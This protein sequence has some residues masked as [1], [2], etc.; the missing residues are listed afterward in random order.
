MLIVLLSWFPCFFVA[1]ASVIGF[2]FLKS[3]K[4]ELRL[5]RLE[6]RVA[7]GPAENNTAKAE[8]VPVDPQPAPTAKPFQGLN[9]TTRS[10]VLKMHWL[11]QSADQIAG[12][13]GLQKGEVDLLIKVHQITMRAL[14]NPS[15]PVE[16]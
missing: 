15:S 16:A 12:K 6:S 4:N 10:K 1:A 9:S 2:I 14:E 3:I 11:G 5:L 8:P 13:L 7:S